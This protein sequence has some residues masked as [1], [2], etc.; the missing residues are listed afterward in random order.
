[1]TELVP[2]KPLPKPPPQPT[3]PADGRLTV[4]DVP[5]RG[6]RRLLGRRCLH[7]FLK[8]IRKSFSSMALTTSAPKPQVRRQR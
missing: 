3:P 1:M 6:E 4:S 8:L 5:I 7:S 2:T